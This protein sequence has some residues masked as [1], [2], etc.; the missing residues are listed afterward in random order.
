M[1]GKPLLLTGVLFFPYF[2]ST[3]RIG[4]IEQDKVKATSPSSFIATLDAVITHWKK[5]IVKQSNLEGRFLD[6]SRGAE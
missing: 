3:Q 6:K 2:F 4:M 5:V 1:R